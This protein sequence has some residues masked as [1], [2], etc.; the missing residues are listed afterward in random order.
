MAFCQKFVTSL[1]LI[2]ME[3]GCVDGSDEFDQVMIATE[4]QQRCKMLAKLAK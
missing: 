1:V 4:V 2:T 3:G